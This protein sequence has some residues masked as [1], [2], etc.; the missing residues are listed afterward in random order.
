M[1]KDVIAVHSLRDWSNVLARWY[2][3]DG[4]GVWPDAK[5]ADEVNSGADMQSCEAGA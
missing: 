4:P 2:A 5:A 3:T 1:K